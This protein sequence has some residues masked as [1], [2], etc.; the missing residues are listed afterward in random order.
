MSKPLTDRQREFFE[1]LGA[2]FEEYGASLGGC[3]CCDS[4]YVVIDGRDDDLG[5]VRYLNGLLTIDDRPLSTFPEFP[6]RGAPGG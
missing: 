4:P 5:P 6:P 2:L 1:K 3:G